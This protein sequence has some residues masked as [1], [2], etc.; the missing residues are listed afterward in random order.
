MKVDDSKWRTGKQVELETGRKTSGGWVESERSPM[1]RAKTQFITR[2]ALNAIVLYNIFVSF[3]FKGRV[4]SE[5]VKLLG[6]ELDS[7]Q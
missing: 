5:W 1:N 2:A 4:K 7:Y 3:Q 6:A